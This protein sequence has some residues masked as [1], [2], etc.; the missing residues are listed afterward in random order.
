MDL[1]NNSY[2]EPFEIMISLRIKDVF[3]FIA[4]EEKQINLTNMTQNITYTLDLLQKEYNSNHTLK[5]NDLDYEFIN[6][7]INHNYTKRR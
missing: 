3:N 6:Y 7:V 5:L 1:N 2:L 4:N